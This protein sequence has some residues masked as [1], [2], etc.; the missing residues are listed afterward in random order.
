M[1]HCVEENSA[2]GLPVMR[3]LFMAAPNEDKAYERENYSYLLGS[4]VLV[5]PVVKP[6]ENKRT[7]WLPQGQWRHM[8]SGEDCSGTVTVDAPIGKPPVFYRTDSAYAQLFE[9][10]AADYC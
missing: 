2:L 3:G 9:K 8:W 6:G 10:L 7:V 5:A 4:D 1:R